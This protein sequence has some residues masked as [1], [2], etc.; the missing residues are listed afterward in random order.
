MTDSPERSLE[1]R[2]AALEVTVERL[3]HTVERLASDR[4]TRDPSRPS[5]PRTAP[6]AV[7][8]GFAARH[9]GERQDHHAAAAPP[10]RVSLKPRS[11]RQDFVSRLLD[12]GPQFWISRVGIGL[13]LAGVVYLFKYAVDQGWLTPPIRVAFGEK[14]H[15]ARIKLLWQR[16][17]SEE[18]VV[19]ADVLFQQAEGDERGLR[20]RYSSRRQTVAYTSK[21]GRLYA[22]TFDWPG[23]EFRIHGPEP[24]TDSSVQM[25]G[26][27]RELPWTWNEGVLTIDTSSIGIRDLPCEHAWTFRLS[28]A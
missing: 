28:D 16:G 7:Q 11:G 5:T 24:A 1:E 9:T 4:Q 20:A 2:L 13:L 21:P 18:E 19:P 12:R 6:M 25:L 17:S 23:D 8:P 26:L 14:T 22:I 3:Q 27:E 15:E 10:A